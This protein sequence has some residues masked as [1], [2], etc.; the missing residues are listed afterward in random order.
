MS[1][2]LSLV[3]FFV[4]L[5]QAQ[6]GPKGGKGPQVTDPPTAAIDTPSP[7]PAPT[8]EPTPPQPTANPVEPSLTPEPTS[9]PTSDICLNTPSKFIYRYYK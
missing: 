2:L 3:L 9:N 1:L 5:S 6:K 8:S 4:T 7:I